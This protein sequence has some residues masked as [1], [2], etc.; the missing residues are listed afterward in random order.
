MVQPTAVKQLLIEPFGGLAGDMF[1]AALLDL[2]DERFDLAQLQRLATELV[3]EGCQLELA[4]T[5]RASISALSLLVQTPESAHPPHRHL[6]D[7]LEML[8]ACSLGIDATERAGRVLRRIAEAE[9]QV[10]GTSVEGVHFHEVG[11]VDTLID[12]A[13]ACLGLERLGL[14]RVLSTT[15]YAGSGSVRCAHGEMPV[16]APG[17]LGILRGLPFQRGPGGER[18]TPTGAALLAEFVDHF[19]PSEALISHAVG[20]GAGQRDPE[21]GPPNLVRLSLVESSSSIGNDPGYETAWLLECNL[22]D[23]SGE[24]LGFLLQ[25]LRSHGALEAW[26]APVQMKKDRPGVIL[27]ALARAEQRAAL[28]RLCFEHSPTLG[29]RWSVVQRRECE[30]ELLELQID[31]ERM[32]F[33]LRLPMAGRPRAGDLFVEYDDLARLA[34]KRGQGLREVERQVL[35]QARAAFE[36]GA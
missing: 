22:D 28:E 21:Q 35:A 26:S 33:K 34:R 12:V 20:Y 18:L 13:G 31:G 2:G 1:L 23:A 14:E 32:R 16:P 5:Q 4:R 19:E 6:S 25:E 3:P 10:H 8:D 30:R 7:L 17:T 11:A 27:S 15:P 36:L 29:L 9:A 24:E